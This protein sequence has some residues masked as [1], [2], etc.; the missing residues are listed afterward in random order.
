V[1]TNDVDNEIIDVKCRRPLL[2]QRLSSID[3]W[4]A[5]YLTHRITNAMSKAFNSRIQ[6][7]KSAARGF[8]LFSRFRTRILF[9][10]GSLDLQPR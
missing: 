2:L 5:S 7:L 10:L 3:R 8:H 1:T 9:F 4:D 6:S